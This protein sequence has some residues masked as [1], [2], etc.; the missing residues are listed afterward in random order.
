MIENN[1]LE[2]GRKLRMGK[3]AGVGLE[4]DARE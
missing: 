2:Q 3:R 4:M 1:W